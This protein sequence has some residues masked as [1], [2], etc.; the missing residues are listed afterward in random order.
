MKRF[1]ATLVF[2]L[3]AAMT[4]LSGQ[5]AYAGFAY[6]FETQPPAT[7]TITNA[8]YSGA[9]SPTFSSSVSGGVL[10]FNDTTLPTDGGA[11]IGAALETSQVFTDV[12]ASATLNPAG[13]SDNVLAVSVRNSPAT[14][15]GYA[16]T[17][18][19]TEGTLSVGKVMANRPVQVVASTDFSQGRQS[20]LTDLARSYFLQVDA[21]GNH[22]DARVF[23]SP[24]GA[25]LLTVNYTD[26][27]VGGPAFKSGVSGLTTM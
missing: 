9:S 10:R 12:R 2:G 15:S 21:V 6:D 7:F 8:L 3:V 18:D 4:C 19:F 11:I 22:L 16:V 25:Q 24:G 17:F 20:P 26:T 13:T 14:L 5:A 23:D 1:G 27:G